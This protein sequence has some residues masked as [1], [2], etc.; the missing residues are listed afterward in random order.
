MQL[1]GRF[2]VG[3]D[4]SHTVPEA[5]L[6]RIREVEA[7]LT[8][9]QRHSLRWTLTWLERKPVLSLDDGPTLRLDD[10]DGDD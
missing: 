4:F 6:A 7:Q 5:M 1:G 3:Y 9:D 2:D 8:D 10:A